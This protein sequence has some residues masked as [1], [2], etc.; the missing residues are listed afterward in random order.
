MKISELATK[1]KIP[2]ETIH[3]YV[4]EGLIPKPR[5]MGSNLAEYNELHAEQIQLIRQIQTHFFLPLSLI[6]KIVKHLKLVWT[7]SHPRKPGEGNQRQRTDESSFLSP[8][9]Q[10]GKG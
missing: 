9:S 2:K 7:D 6:K 3:Y 8:L 4:R 1:T 5:K 10:V